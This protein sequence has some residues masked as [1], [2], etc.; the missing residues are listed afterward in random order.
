MASSGD[1]LRSST[2]E[3]AQV[4]GSTLSLRQNP[5][6]LKS[7]YYHLSDNVEH[8]RSNFALILDFSQKI[9][10]IGYFLEPQDSMTE[11]GICFEE[12]LFLAGKF[13]WLK[14]ELKC[15][16]IKKNWQHQH[17]LGSQS[18]PLICSKG[19]WK[20]NL[21]QFKNGGCLIFQNGLHPD[22][23][24]I[25]RIECAAQPTNWT[26]FF[27]IDQ[28]KQ[29]KRS[30]WILPFLEEIRKYTSESYWMKFWRLCQKLK[31]SP[32]KYLAKVQL[33]HIFRIELG[34]PINIWSICNPIKGVDR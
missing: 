17:P 19:S 27:T 6:G 20:K 9:Q 26:I 21:I 24:N 23:H 11:K 4:P 12:T 22:C 31:D 32:L 15:D 2:G 34:K 13:R 29:K 18:T 33:P 14:Y 3:S 25:N 28:Y 1:R 8:M 10:E 30:E 16:W 7:N 5:Q